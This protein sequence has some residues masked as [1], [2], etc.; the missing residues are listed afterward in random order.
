MHF[1]I[2]IAALFV[3]IMCSSVA[4]IVEDQNTARQKTG[5]GDT[6]HVH[7][8]V[9]SL[10]GTKKLTKAAGVMIQLWHDIKFHD[11][12]WTAEMEGYV[13]VCPKF[14]VFNKDSTSLKCCGCGC[15]FTSCVLSM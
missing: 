7:F 6:V 2:W 1:L 9:W 10:M 3:A 12:P 14:I 5:K 13:E 8:K 15:C 11:C 4:G